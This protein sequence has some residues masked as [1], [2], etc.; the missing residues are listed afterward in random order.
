MAAVP[1]MTVLKVDSVVSEAD[2]PFRPGLGPL[3]GQ[4]RKG[5]DCGY[6]DE[7]LQGDLFHFLSLLSLDSE[8]RELG[9]PSESSRFQ[10]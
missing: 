5:S 10:C 9:L 2:S 3:G 8:D 6:C 4:H 1:A 7:K